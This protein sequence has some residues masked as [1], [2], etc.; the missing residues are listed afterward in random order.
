MGSIPVAIVFTCQNMETIALK[1]QKHEYRWVVKIR[2]TSETV[3]NTPLGHCTD[4]GPIGLGAPRG[5][6]RTSCISITRVRMSL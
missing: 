3:H 4:C 2:N 6:L 1:L 5:V